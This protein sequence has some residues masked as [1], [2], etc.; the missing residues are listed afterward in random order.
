MGS[1][2]LELRKLID[3]EV[4]DNNTKHLAAG[5]RHRFCDHFL[6][7]QQVWQWTWRRS[8][9]EETKHQAKLNCDIIDIK[10]RAKEAPSQMKQGRNFVVERKQRTW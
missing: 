3:Y 1:Q 4:R 9:Y 7:D 8:K 5:T 2:W 10:I 6:R